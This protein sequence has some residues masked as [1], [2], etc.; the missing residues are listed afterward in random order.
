MKIIRDENDIMIGIQGSGKNG[1]TSKDE[2]EFCLKLECERYKKE[3]IINRDNYQKAIDICKINCQKAIDI[4]KIDCQKVINTC[5]I[6]CQKAI[7][8]LDLKDIN[9]PTKQEENDINVK[10]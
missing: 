5:E 10:H 4:C 1:M 6:N 8:N 3:M 2:L 9:K 7:S